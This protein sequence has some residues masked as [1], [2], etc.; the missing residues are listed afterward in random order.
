MEIVTGTLAVALVVLC[1][2][3]IW[4]WIKEDNLDKRYQDQM[5]T[6]QQAVDG[7]SKENKRLQSIIDRSQRAYK[8]DF[9]REVKLGGGN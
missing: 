2:I 7:L 3:L 6:L 9:R 5:Q 8:K 1:G 4:R